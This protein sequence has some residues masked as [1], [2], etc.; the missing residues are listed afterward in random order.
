M[1][2]N[3]SFFR[4]ITGNSKFH[5]M[6]SKMKIICFLLS[7]IISLLISNYLSLLIF[8][9][10]LMFILVKTEIKLNVYL[11]NVLVLWPIYVILFIVCFMTTF[12][13]LF[14][15]LMV[16]K[17]IVIVVLCLVLTFTT[18]LSEIAWGFEC[19]FNPLKKFGIPVSKISLG[20]ALS[21]KFIS[22]LFDKF[23]EVRKSMAYRGVPYSKSKITSFTK[24]TIPVIRL[25]YRLSVRTIAAMKLRF[26]GHSN[27]RTNYHENKVSKFDKVLVFIDVV[28]L[29]VVLWMRWV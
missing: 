10:F 14:S 24:M 18:S 23:K 19:L 21:I 26:Y 6:N 5:T 15:L 7:I 22:T 12:D 11:T 25:S 27:K 13:M 28:L 2:S 16:L 29:Y 20:I 17:I 4:Y 9:L 1:K 3:Y 8:S